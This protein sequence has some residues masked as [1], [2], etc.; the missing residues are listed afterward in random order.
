M[1]L[2][3]CCTSKYNSTAPTTAPK[4]LPSFSVPLS[5]T[6]AIIPRQAALA[7]ILILHIRMAA[8]DSTRIRPQARGGYTQKL[9]GLPTTTAPTY[10]GRGSTVGTNLHQN[11]PL[12]PTSCLRQGGRGAANDGARNAPFSLLKRKTAIQRW[13]LPPH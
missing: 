6:A 11:M 4:P 12:P 1:R 10:S 5:L 9:L 2:T 7:V 3:L 13:N 8:K